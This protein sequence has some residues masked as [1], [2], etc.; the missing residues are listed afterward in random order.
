MDPAIAVAA[1]HPVFNV[2]PER[3]DAARAWFGAL[4]VPQ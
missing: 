1:T 4:P 2:R 3:V